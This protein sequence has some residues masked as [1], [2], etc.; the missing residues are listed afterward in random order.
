MRRMRY[1]DERDALRHRVDNLEQDLAVARKEL[2]AKD[3]HEQQRRVLQLE[4]RVGA[5]RAMLSD[6]EHELAQVRAQKPARSRGLVAVAVGGGVALLAVLA[7]VFL[8]RSSAEPPPPMPVPQPVVTFAPPPTVAPL[9][10]PEPARPEPPKP[11]SRTLDATWSA[12]VTKVTGEAP[13]KVGATCAVKGKLGAD[14]SQ[15]K[16]RGVVLQCGDAV[17]YD[18]AGKFNGMSQRGGVAAEE[19]APNGVGQRYAMVFDDVGARTGKPQ[20]SVNTEKRSVALWTESAPAFRVELAADTWSGV[21]GG[22]PLLPTTKQTL[23]ATAT[24]AKVNGPAPVRKGDSCREEWPSGSKAAVLK[25]ADGASR[26]GVRISSPPL[27]LARSRA[28]RDAATRTRKDTTGQGGTGI[29][30]TGW[31]QTRR[32]K[33]TEVRSKSSRAGCSSRSS[34]W[35]NSTR[36]PMHQNPYFSRRRVNASRP[37]SMTDA[38]SSRTS[39]MSIAPCV[40][41]VPPDWS[42]AV[43]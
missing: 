22:E 21:V 33:R 14:G 7:A 28:S 43:R 32:W 4:E 42:P 2:E 34:P 9:P 31:K 36:P 39:W 41:M 40:L 5:L 18:L 37:P 10:A 35:T 8:I 16:V 17:L 19:L 15:A 6:V 12:K 1:R 27:N 3:D 30:V 25:T 26:P 23:L 11:P 24:V 20:L 38:I 29:L 13:V